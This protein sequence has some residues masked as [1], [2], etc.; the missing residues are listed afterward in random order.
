MDTHKSQDEELKTQDDTRQKMSPRDNADII[1]KCLTARDDYGIR[2]TTV[3]RVYT[4]PKIEVLDMLSD[5]LQCQVTKTCT[6]HIYKCTYKT[7]PP[8][9]LYITD[10]LK[11]NMEAVN[12]PI[13]ILQQKIESAISAYNE[14]KTARDILQGKKEVLEKQFRKVLEDNQAMMKEAQVTLRFKN[15]P[16]KRRV[17]STD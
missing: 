9:F 6:E 14:V 1:F 8:F 13:Y 2:K 3:E 17:N 11:F 4:C 15:A 12:R 5:F 7:E 10:K 16:K